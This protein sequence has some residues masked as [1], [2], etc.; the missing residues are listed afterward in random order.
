[1]NSKSVSLPRGNNSGAQTARTKKTNTRGK[2]K[3]AKYLAG[4]A[5]TS[6]Q[7][8]HG[9]KVIGHS[10]VKIVKAARTAS[11]LANMSEDRID[12]KA[13]FTA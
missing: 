10:G 2:E 8:T 11:R 4:G 1:M 13:Y 12:D 7:T 9:K 3:L 5:S 6:K